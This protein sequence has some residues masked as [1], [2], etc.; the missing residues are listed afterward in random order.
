[1]IPLVKPILG[2]AEKK[3]VNEVI[4]SGIIAA[5]KYVE[6]FE[7]KCAELHGTKFGVATSNGTTALHTA[8]I[9][10]GIKR[11]DKILTTPFTFIATSNSIL[12][13]GAIPVFADIDNETF[14]LSPS[15]CEEIL[16][17]QRDIKA[18]L[19]VHLYGMPCDMDAFLRIKNKYNVIL[20]EDCAQAHGAKY[21]HKTV[22]GFADVSAFSFY[23][24]KNVTTGEGG[25]VLTDSHE[26]YSLSKQVI[27]HGRSEH[28]VHNILGYNYRLT[29][30]SA[31]IGLAQIGRM[32][33]WNKKRQDNAG[34]LSENLKGLAFLKVPKM[35]DG[36]EPVFH[37]Y[38]LRVDSKIRKNLMDHLTKNEIGCGVYYPFAVYNQPLYQSMGFNKGLCPN[39]EKAAEEV[40]S[41]PVH[42][43]LSKQDLEKIVSV[44]RN[45]K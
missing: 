24:T 42:P 41:I 36:Y 37:Q 10:S 15:K 5:G 38:T 1:M 9:A 17:K 23:A 43:A 3:L 14:N 22:G 25:V 31:A 13:C 44:I 4:D 27:N 35:L 2:A 45:F 18:V 32:E 11:G 30:I 7:K 34:Y 33:E 26:V 29:N 39:A 20:I 19:L 28:S 40:L 8:L 21:K 16:E 6:E 12:Y